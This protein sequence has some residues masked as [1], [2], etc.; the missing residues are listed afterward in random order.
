VVLPGLVDTPFF[1]GRGGIPVRRAPRPVS[2]ETV[3][4]AIAG[5]ID[6]DRPEVWVPGW[7]RTAAV[8][9][10]SSPGLFRRLSV[11]YGEPVR[12]TRDHRPSP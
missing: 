6:D 5:A 11:R 2:P 4:R 10:G 3:A 7:L 12:I 8:V 9:R 1:E